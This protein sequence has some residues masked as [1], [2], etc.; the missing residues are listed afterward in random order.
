MTRLTCGPYK[1]QPNQSPAVVLLS[2]QVF[3]PPLQPDFKMEFTDLGAQAGFEV[4]L[5]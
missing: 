4:F 1:L 2:I 5:F 3:R